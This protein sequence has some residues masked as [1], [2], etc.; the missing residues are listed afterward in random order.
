MLIEFLEKCNVDARDE[1]SIG[2]DGEGRLYF[3]IDQHQFT[4]PL[5][6]NLDRAAVQRVATWLAEWLRETEVSD[7][8]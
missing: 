7:A 4:S 1:L 8:D 2:N 6:V 3:N 5:Q